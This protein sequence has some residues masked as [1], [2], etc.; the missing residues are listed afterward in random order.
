MKNTSIIFY[1]R[2]GNAA[3]ELGVKIRSEG[4]YAQIRHAEAFNGE[5]ELCERVVMLPCVTAHD[6]KRIVATYGAI[7]APLG[8]VLPPPPPPPPVDPL[9]SLPADWREQDY[10]TLRGVAIAAC[11]GRTPENRKQAVQMIEAALKAKG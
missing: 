3:K 7:A 2:D 5:K 9:A 1:G 10:G 4:A 11:G 6:T 8:T